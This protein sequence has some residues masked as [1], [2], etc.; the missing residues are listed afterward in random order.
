MP[1]TSIFEKQSS[2]YKNS[3]LKNLPKV[4]LEASAENCWHKMAEK[5]DLVLS[6]TEFG[7]SGSPKEVLNHFGFDEKGIAKAILN[8]QKKI[9]KQ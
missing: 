8:W 7:K 3:V 5:T 1:C 6:L 9:N 4:F 2:A